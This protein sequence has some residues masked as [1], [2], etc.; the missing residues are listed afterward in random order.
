MASGDGSGRLV[1]YCIGCR[2]YPADGTALLPQNHSP[3]RPHLLASWPDD[4]GFKCVLSRN[5]EKWP[6]LIRPHVAMLACITHADGGMLRRFARITSAMPPKMA[7]DASHNRIV[8]GSPNSNTPPT[9]AITGT[10]S[11]RVAAL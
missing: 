8:M 2:F 7:T 4:D 3:G 5:T 6:K 1:W 11:C 9:A 10:L